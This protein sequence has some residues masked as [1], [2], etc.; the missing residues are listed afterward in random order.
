MMNIDW[1]IVRLGEVLKSISRPETVQ[2]H[3]TY[4]ILGSHWYAKGLYTKAVLI[5]T[6][7]K[8]SKVFRVEKD[9]FVYNRLFGWKGSFAV[10]TDVNHNCYVSNEFPCFII[11]HGRLDKRYLWRYFS[12]ESAWLEALGLSSGGT[13]TSR[14]RLK[15]NKLLAMK[16]PLPPSPN[17]V[18]L[19]PTWTTCKPKSKRSNATRLPPRPGWIAAVDSR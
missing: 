14:N 6:E 18:A 12:R 7:I 19:S 15:E 9:D 10:A 16:I 8:A 3:K 1:P 2:A 4:N 13:P 5:G 17:N 11:D